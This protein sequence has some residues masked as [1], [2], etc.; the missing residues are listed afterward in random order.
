MRE[1]NDKLRHSLIIKF[2]MLESKRL[3]WLDIAKGVAIIL[4]VLG[5]TS[6]P[7]QLSNFIFAFH[8]PLFFI[9]S[10]WCTD[11]TKDNYGAFVLKK[12]RTLGIPF[13][14]YSVSVIIIAWLAGYQGIELR[15]VLIK[16]WEGYALWFVPVLFLSLVIAKSIM[17]FIN[18]AWFRYAVCLL[19]ILGGALLRYYHIYL[20]WTLATVPYATCLVL[21]GSSLREFQKYIDKPRWW[22]FVVCLILTIAISQNWRLDLAWNNIIP[23]V[24]LTVG[25]ISGTAMVFTLSSWLN[26]Q[27]RFSFVSKV[28]MA[29]GKETF[30]I[31][32]FS[33]IIIVALN[34]HTELGSAIRYACLAVALAILACLKNF[35]NH[36]VGKRVL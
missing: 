29:I 35:I 36:I 5:H 15:G 34:L 12:M 24:I 9:A 7:D 19:L 11:W 26:K 28:L 27:T 22:I 23:V 1:L 18:I 16:G 31:M 30:I 10:G 14:V 8:M 21:L 6:I 4:M 25:A 13:L 3:E 33:Q 32:A 20:G 2:S 17:C